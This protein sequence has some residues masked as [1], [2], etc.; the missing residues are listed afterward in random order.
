MGEKFFTLKRISGQNRTRW[1]T[2]GEK[3][4]VALPTGC[5]Q[6][7]TG[8]TSLFIGLVVM[9]GCSTIFVGNHQVIDIEAGQGDTRIQIKSENSPGEF[10]YCAD[11]GR[12]Q[13][14]VPKSYQGFLLTASAGGFENK[15]IKVKP[16]IELIFWGN[17]LLGGAPGMLIDAFTG[18]MWTYPRRINV[19]LVQVPES[20]QPP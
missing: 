14:I 5:G 11:S 1:P 9:I 19:D 3:T 20:K 13:A 8:V 10:E 15:T 17:C 18:S 2:A 6:F 7:L 16:D 12:L 4:K